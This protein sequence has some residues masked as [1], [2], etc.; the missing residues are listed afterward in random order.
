M[1]AAISALH[2]RN[3]QIGL[4]IPQVGEVAQKDK[5]GIKVDLGGGLLLLFY[6]LSIPMRMA[7]AYALRDLST[8]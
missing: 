3:N 6:F 5:A 1:G 4:R 7:E 8:Q 2:S